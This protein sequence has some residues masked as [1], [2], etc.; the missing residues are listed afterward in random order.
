MVRRI[1][2]GHGRRPLLP[3]TG[4]GAKE[5]C[6]HLLRRVVVGTET[7]KHINPAA[8]TTSLDA[9]RAASGGV[10]NELRRACSAPC[11]ASPLRASS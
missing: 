4:V 9:I 11:R 7:E 10:G 8:F 5:K 6:P 1:G 2:N 3:L